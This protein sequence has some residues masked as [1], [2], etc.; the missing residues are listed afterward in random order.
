M[1]LHWYILNSGVKTCFG[2]VRDVLMY[3]RRHGKRVL[4]STSVRV[5]VYQR[6]GGHAHVYVAGVTRML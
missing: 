6:G 5:C 2:D 4:P 1:K 3:G